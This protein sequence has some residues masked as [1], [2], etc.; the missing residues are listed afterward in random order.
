MYDFFNYTHKIIVTKILIHINSKQLDFKIANRF[1]FQICLQLIKRIKKQN[2]Q[3]FF[4][5]LIIM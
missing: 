4:G 3:Y 2:K 1:S 5:D